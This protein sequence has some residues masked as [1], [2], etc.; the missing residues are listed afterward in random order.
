MKCSSFVILFLLVLLN[1]CSIDSK[2]GS[3]NVTAPETPIEKVQNCQKKIVTYYYD[4]TATPTMV[5]TCDTI[6]VK[7]VTKRLSFTEYCDFVYLEANCV[8][9]TACKYQGTNYLLASDDS[10]EKCKSSAIVMVD[11]TFNCRNEQIT[12]YSYSSHTSEIEQC[13]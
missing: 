7:H 4:T 2:D 1:A 10:V 9:N 8:K 11:S 5:Y 3:T 13:D 12:L 6:K